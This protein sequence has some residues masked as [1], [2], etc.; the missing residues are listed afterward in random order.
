MNKLRYAYAL[1]ESKKI[2]HISQVTKEMKDGTHFFCISC[3][4][5]MIACLGEVNQHYFRHKN[6]SEC[7]EETYLHKLGKKI[8]KD[9]FVNSKEFNI[10]ITQVETC[11]T[12]KKCP[13]FDKATCKQNALTL[14]NLKDY[15]NI[16]EEEKAFGKYV[17]DLLLYSNVQ[18]VEPVMLEICVTHKCS[19]EKINSGYKIIE[20]TLNNEEDA[21]KL[22]DAELTDSRENIHFYNFKKDKKSQKP[23]HNDV[24]VALIYK[25]GNTYLSGRKDG[26]S[27]SNIDIDIDDTN[28][29]YND[30]IMRVT[31]P[32]YCSNLD[33]WLLRYAHDEGYSIRNCKV[34]KFYK[35]NN[36]RKENICTLYKKYGT[37]HKPLEYEANA[38]WCMSKATFME[39]E[40]IV[41]TAGQPI[42]RVNYGLGGKPERYILGRPVVLVPASYLSGV[43]AF[44]FDFAD[45]V[46]NTNYG[47]AIKKYED[48]A[49]DDQVTKAIMLVDG[50]KVDN[51]SLVT[52]AK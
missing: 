32:D 45:Y 14:F 34:C 49:T 20:I 16:C 22:M 24:Y 4:D 33:L 29:P 47:V 13:L 43:D 27:C 2:V 23:L 12:K 11:C 52:L 36:Y 5:E 31:T 40:G 19:Q 6:V 3:G 18:K 7:N 46:V 9:R 25:N 44:I 42:A 35:Y 1:N 37:P 28:T 26:W 41:D 21:I 17:A 48:N 10:S 8:L 15:Y 51:G 30:V 38:K 39:I 50:K